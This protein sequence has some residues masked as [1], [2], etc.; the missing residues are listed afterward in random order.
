M[1]LFL[2]SLIVSICITGIYTDDQ[3][4]YMVMF[5]I[6]LNL[7]NLLESVVSS[8]FAKILPKSVSSNLFNSGFLIILFVTIG[9]TF[10]SLMYTLASKIDVSKLNL[11][12]YAMVS[13]ALVICIVL[14]MVFYGSLR[15]KALA[16][17]LKRNVNGS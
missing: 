13:G 16:R 5:F 4:H 12:L 1:Y 14:G 3:Y 10:G 2:A 6:L 11:W 17:I 9:K 15:V 8:L 7:G